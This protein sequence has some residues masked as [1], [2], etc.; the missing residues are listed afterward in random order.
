[1]YLVSFKA[2]YLQTIYQGA[3]V[4]ARSKRKMSLLWMYSLREADGRGVQAKEI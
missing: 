2:L 4:L 3:S 1:M